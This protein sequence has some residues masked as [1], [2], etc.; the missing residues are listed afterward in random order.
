MLEH[1]L[2]LVGRL[3]DRQD[4]AGPTVDTIINNHHIS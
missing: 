2:V 4:A 1:K 3:D